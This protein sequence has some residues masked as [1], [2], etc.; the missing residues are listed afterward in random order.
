MEMKDLYAGLLVRATD[1]SAFRIVIVIAAS[2]TPG[3]V[4]VSTWSDNSRSWS[5]VHTQRA[6]RLEPLGDVAQLRPGQRAAVKH[7]VQAVA[8]AHGRVLTPDEAFSI[9]KVRQ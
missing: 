1:Y 2:R 8:D 7:V 3:K 6:D 4:R 9:G 5:N